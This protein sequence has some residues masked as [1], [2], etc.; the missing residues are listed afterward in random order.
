MTDNNTDKTS[1][2]EGADL[3]LP[4]DD[5]TVTTLRTVRVVEG[6]HT[7]D[8]ENTLRTLEEQKG[9]VGDSEN[10]TF[11]LKGVTYR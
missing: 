5:S 2:P 6:D 3:P 1:L 9:I 10:S 11:V 8:I 7:Q 4:E